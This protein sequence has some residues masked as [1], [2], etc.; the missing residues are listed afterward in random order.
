MTVVAA[1]LL[2]CAQV[3][4]QSVPDRVW[5]MYQY[6]ADHNAVFA[7]P[8]WE[9]TWRSAPSG[10]RINGGLSV[11]GKTLYF[12]SFNQIGSPAQTVHAVDALTGQERWQKTLPNVVMNTPVVVDGL[13]IVGTGI[14]P[15]EPPLGL[16]APL[17]GRPQGDA[18]Y[19]LNAATGSVV[20]K[21][22]TVG[23]NMPTPVYYNNDGRA[24][25]SFTGG[26]LHVYALQAQTGKLLWQRPAPG[27]DM[28]SSLALYDGLVYGITGYGFPQY[29]KIYQQRGPEAARA[30]F[31]HT[32]AIDPAG[33]LRWSMP[34]GQFGCSPTVAADTVFVESWLPTDARNPTLAR[35]ALWGPP[36]GWIVYN[37]AIETS[38]NEVAALDGRTGKLVW[39]R[40]FEP[41]V[42]TSEGSHMD[43]VAG[44]YDDGRFYESIPINR[45][46]S[47]F[48][49]KTGATLWTMQTPDPVKMS[50][51]E[52]DGVLYFGDAS[53]MLY[54][55]RAADGRVLKMVR[56]P[57]IFSISPPVIVGGSLFVANGKLVYAMRLADLQNGVGPVP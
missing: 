18:I 6:A 36:G 28:M 41:G 30:E 5:P 13:V 57:S 23:Q 34:F 15:G 32:W 50:A 42:A 19:A 33:G 2:S 47:A 49:A 56:F 16:Q 39:L 17:S 22:D 48:D 45:T 21:F 38:H 24:E 46:F 55:V 8:D 1:A 31:Q 3:Q 10:G 27:I 53:G 52:K 25:I 14:D 7:A 44:V 54:L 43:A 12:E 9:V 20:W 35:L 29:D 26:D 4:A 51:I 40:R 37:I 11:V